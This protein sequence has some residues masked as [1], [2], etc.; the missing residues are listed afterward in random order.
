LWK[1]EKQTQNALEIAKQGGALYDKFISFLSDIEKLGTQLGTVRNTYD[2]IHKKLSSGTGNLIRRTQ[3]LKELGAKA[4]KKL[5]SS[6]IDSN[7]D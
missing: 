5:P 4:T 7:E 1:H 2:E 6:F 3:K